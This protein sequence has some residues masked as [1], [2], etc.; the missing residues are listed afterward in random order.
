[1]SNPNDDDNNT[2]IISNTSEQSLPPTP[3]NPEPPTTISPSHPQPQPPKQPLIGLGLVLLSLLALSFENVVVHIIFNP[4]SVIGVS[5]PVGGF[6]VPTLSNSLLILWLRMLVVVPLIAILG[7][8]FYPDVWRDIGQNLQSKN[9][10]LFANLFCSGFVLFLS[11]VLIFLALG[12]I[13]PGV[14]V[15]IFFLYPIILLLLSDRFT[16][17]KNF[18]IFS[19]VMV[20]FVLSTL[21][22][23]SNDDV[24]RLGIMAAAGSGIAFALHLML[25]QTCVK[26][27]H[28]IPILWINLAIVLLLSAL[29]LLLPWSGLWTLTIEPTH[30]PSLMISGLVLGGATLLSYLFNYI[31]MAKIG[32][33]RASVVGATLPGLTSLLALILIQN[34]LQIPQILGIVFVTLGVAALNFHRPHHS[35]KRNQPTQSNL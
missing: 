18:L 3:P 5:V 34:T 26:K 27:L 9:W 12:L 16:G 17:S 8:Y 13:A 7:T 1:M 28:P 33:A 15:T 21:P 11:K 35:P 23:S 24:S 25:M 6:I 20:G 29:S 10:R 31:G 4:S 30:L 22:S 19:S 14:A 2:T 32:A